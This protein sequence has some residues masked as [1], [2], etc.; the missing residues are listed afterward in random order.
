M[1]AKAASLLTGTMALILSVGLMAAVEAQAP[2]S[3]GSVRLPQAVM[4]NG[5]PLPAGSYTLR[6][7]SEAVT[8]VVGQSPD[9]AQW[10]EFVQGGQ[11]RGRELATKMTAADAK[12][13]AESTPPASGTAKVQLLKG[14][15]YVRV[16]INNGGTHYL[17]H[18]ATAQR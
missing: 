6:L 1:R 8:P 2:T 16:W 4:A 9:S 14:A 11:V 15:D 18:L 12:A 5:Q 13:I 10:V 7:S 17:L 3:L